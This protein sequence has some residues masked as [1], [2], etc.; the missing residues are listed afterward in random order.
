[1]IMM[2]APPSRDPPHGADLTPVAVGDGP[3]GR[4]SP[5]PVAAGSGPPPAG[6]WPRTRCAGVSRP[7]SRRR[8]REREPARRSSSTELVAM[9]A[10]AVALAGDLS[11]ADVPARLVDEAVE[12]CGGLD[13]LVS[14]AALRHQAP[15][16]ELT[17]A[18]W[19]KVFDVN[20]KATWL[21]ARAAHPALKESGGAIVAVSSIAGIFPHPNYGPYAASKAA[22]VTLCQQMA[23]EWARDGIRVNCV[24]PGIV[25]TE[26]A[27]NVYAD[28]DLAARPSRGRAARPRRRSLRARCGHRVAA[29]P[30]GVVHHRPEPLRRRRLHVDA[31]GDDPRPAVRRSPLPRDDEDLDVPTWWGREGRRPRSRSGRSRP[32]TR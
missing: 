26:N 6:S 19:D 18:G 11:D 1:M 4:S 9:G 10:D 16:L 28:P 29:Q 2:D 3:C 30:G 31:H 17:V 12:F 23:L 5:G 15:L 14:N 24:A 25:R 13:A 32:T 20:T 22:L 27:A 7:A 21:L 8:R